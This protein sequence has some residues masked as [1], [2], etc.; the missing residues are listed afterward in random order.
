MNSHQEK[1]KAIAYQICNAYDELLAQFNEITACAKSNFE[2]KKYA[3]TFVKQQERYVLYRNYA[4]NCIQYAQEQLQEACTSEDIWAKIKTEF[5]RLIASKPYRLNSETFYNSVV[6]KIFFDKSFNEQIE[7]FDFNDYRPQRNEEAE[8]KIVT[9]ILAM[10]FSKVTIKQLLQTCHFSIPF[11]DIDRDAEMIFNEVAPTIIYQKSNLYLTHIEILNSIFYRNRGAFIV[12][13][14]VYNDWYM[15]FVIPILND[16]GGLFV[17]SIVYTQAEISVIFSFT[18]ASFMVNTKYPAQLIDYLKKLLPYKAV[19]ELYDSIGYYRHGKTILYRDLMNYTLNHEDK[20]VIAPGI[21]GMVMTVFTLKYY[22]FVFKIIKDKFENPK[23]ITRKEVIKK[24]E[25]VEL[26]DRVGRMAYA[27]LF[28]NLIFPRNLFAFELIQEFKEHCKET[29]E[30]IGNNVLIKHV[31][32]ERKMTPLNIYLQEANPIDKCKAILDYGFC[33]KEL[34]AANIFPGDL[35]MKNFG[36]TRHGRVIFYDYDEIQQLTELRFRRLPQ[37][38]DY[39]DDRF[40]QIDISADQNDIFPE[41]FKSFMVPDGPIGEVFMA[42]HG[43]I[44][45]PKLWINIQKKVRQGE[46][47]RFYA[48]DKSRRF[49]N[50]TENDFLDYK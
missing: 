36:V 32:L 22:N 46:Y 40:S 33:V 29:V 10:H 16:E 19:G 14:F 43:D 5:S 45:T 13:R 6:R 9:T 27:H 41:E 30:F 26:N 21:K 23:T 15:P 12:G 50:K 8:K 47:L 34:A 2:Q 3:E 4:K 1:I 38:D 31:Y 39:D 28:E 48:Y 49:K 20:F 7:F 11:E 24:Y 42:E 44:F 17:D 35:L 25:E 18:R 37:P